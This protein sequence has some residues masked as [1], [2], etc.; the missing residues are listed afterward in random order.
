MLNEILEWLKPHS[1][2]EDKRELRLL[3]RG[4][5]EDTIKS[6]TPLEFEDFR[7]TW[8]KIDQV[9]KLEAP[10]KRNLILDKEEVKNFISKI[11]E[12]V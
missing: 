12:W 2:I 8:D 9:L 6:N 5:Y 7:L 3:S 4:V 11:S 1:M 10:T